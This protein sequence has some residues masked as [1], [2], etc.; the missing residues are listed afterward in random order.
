LIFKK[1]K[2]SVENDGARTEKEPT[3]SQN[4]M[5]SLDNIEFVR[6]APEEDESSPRSLDQGWIDLLLAYSAVE[7]RILNR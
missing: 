6:E 3:S 7:K 4:H 5:F 2:V 1:R